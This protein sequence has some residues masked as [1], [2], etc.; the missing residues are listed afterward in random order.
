MLQWAVPALTGG[1]IAIGAYADEQYRAE[2]VGRGLVQ[3]LMP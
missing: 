1:I 3:R 2:E